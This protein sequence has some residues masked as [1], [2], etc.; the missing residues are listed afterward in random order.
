MENWNE[1]A[2][3]ARWSVSPVSGAFFRTGHRPL[4]FRLSSD[5]PALAA[6]LFVFDWLLILAG[7]FLDP[8]SRFARIFL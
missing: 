2:F 3:H 4:L 6:G 7:L 8:P 5:S 1:F